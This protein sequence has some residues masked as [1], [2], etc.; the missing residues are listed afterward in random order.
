MQGEYKSLDSRRHQLQFHP[1][2]LIKKIHVFSPCG[3]DE[4]LAWANNICSLVNHKKA[5]VSP[6]FHRLTG[7]P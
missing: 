2:D 6:H 4:G 5:P 7:A 3:E 1:V